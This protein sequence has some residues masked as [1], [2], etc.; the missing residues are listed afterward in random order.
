MNMN[1][2]LF[3]VAIYFVVFLAA[4]ILTSKM[5]YFKVEDMGQVFGLGSVA[6]GYFAHKIF[7]K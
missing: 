1:N 2:K 6:L 3:L 4:K 7:K 5:A